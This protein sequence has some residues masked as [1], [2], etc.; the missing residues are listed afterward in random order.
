MDANCRQNA[1][2]RRGGGGGGVCQQ[3]SGG[4]EY[5]GCRRGGSTSSPCDS[6]YLDPITGAPPLFLHRVHE[7]LDNVA[8]S[9]R[10]ERIKQVRRFRNKNTPKDKWSSYIFVH[11]FWYYFISIYEFY[12]NILEIQ[13]FQKYFCVSLDSCSSKCSLWHMGF[14]KGK[15]GVFVR[16]KNWFS[17]LYVQTSYSN[18][19]TDWVL[20]LFSWLSR[21]SSSLWKVN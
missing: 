6:G 10:Y 12:S 20:T 19:Q 17:N 16:M 5:G 4:G 9:V 13:Y 21:I 18:I 11:L 1:P 8:E 3:K 14:L 7:M 2:K 15:I